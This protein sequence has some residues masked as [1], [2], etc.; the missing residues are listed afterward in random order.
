MAIDSRYAVCMTQAIA[1]AL[2]NR[3]TPDFLGLG[4]EEDDFEIESG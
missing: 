4:G 3:Y 1:N 2:H